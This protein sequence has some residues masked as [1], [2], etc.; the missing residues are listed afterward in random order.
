[1][2]INLSHLYSEMAQRAYTDYDEYKYLDKQIYTIIESAGIKIYFQ[3]DKEKTWRKEDKLW[4]T[5]NDNSSWKIIDKGS[6][7][8]FFIR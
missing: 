1:K 3:T 7:R 4:V 6:K 8:V 5:T 2:L